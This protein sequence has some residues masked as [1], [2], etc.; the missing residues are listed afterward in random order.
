MLSEIFFLQLFSFLTLIFFINTYNILT[1]WLLA[2]FYLL[3]LGIWLL[4]DDGD[5][6]IGFLWVID[7]GVGLIFFIFVLHYSTFLHHKAKVDK[8]T[9]ELTF[10]LLGTLF[11]SS[12][13]FF[14]SSPT[15]Y[16]FAGGFQKTWFFHISWYDYYDFFYS[17]V[18]TDLN[19]LREIYFYNNSFEFFLINF[20]LFFGIIASILLTFLIKKV[21]S[22]LNFEQLVYWNTL[23][24]LKS[25]YFIRN[26]NYLKQA[27]ASTGT[28]V[29]L[30]KKNTNL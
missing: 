14:F 22:L 24:N 21:F 30:K 4:L 1:L 29:W 15:S 27:S 12:F 18:I 13:F 28:R 23:H 11:L 16:D 19:L 2:G 26:Q 10:H 6:F 3:V 17:Y 7:L 5:I 25:T 9:R 20:L 8:S